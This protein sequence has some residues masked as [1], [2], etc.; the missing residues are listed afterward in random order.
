MAKIHL[1]HHNLWCQWQKFT[2]D[3]IN[4]GVNSDFLPSTPQFVVPPPL[5][6]P[7]T[8]APSVVGLINCLFT[9]VHI[10]IYFCVLSLIT[11][12]PITRQYKIIVSTPFSVF[13]EL[14][15]QES[16]MY[17]LGMDGRCYLWHSSLIYI[18]QKNSVTRSTNIYLVNYTIQNIKNGTIKIFDVLLWY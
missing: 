9:P 2:F 4:C 18:V 12:I 7:W 17:W 6:F 3:T 13:F 16:S 15:W 10:M 11:E 14:T 5:S 8:C 1:R